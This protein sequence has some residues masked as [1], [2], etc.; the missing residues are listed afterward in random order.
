MVMRGRLD[1]ERRQ[2]LNMHEPL[3]LHDIFNSYQVGL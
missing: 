1:Y 3:W 2:L